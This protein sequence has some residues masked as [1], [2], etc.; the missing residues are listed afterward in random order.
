[1]ETLATYTQA[2]QEIT[3]ALF[4]SFVAF[5]DRTEKTTRTYLC[6]L[7]QFMAWLRY[8]AITQPTRPD[9][10][11]Y[12]QWLSTEH[13]AIVFDAASGWR[14]RTDRNGGRVRICCKA[15]TVKGYLQAVKEFFAWTAANGLYPNIAANVHAP[16]IT[17]THKKDALTGAEVLAIE[18]SITATT[19]RRV[20]DAEHA[21]RDP[22]GEAQRCTERGKRLYA[23]YLL[24]VNAG[25]RTV[26][27]SRA[28]V[29]DLE[30][31]DGHAYLY[32]WGKGHSEPDQRKPLAPAV[33]AALRDYL[34]SRTD[35]MTGSSPLFVATSNRSK[36]QRIASTTISTML[37][38]AM[39][40]A[41]FDSE[42]LTAHSL[43]HSTA[44]NVMLVTGRNIYDTQ[45]YLRHSSPK[46]TEIYLENDTTEAD[47]RIA[48]RLYAYYHGESN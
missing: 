21:R 11:S 10:L 16:R 18:R 30:Q 2:A 48:E 13:D 5:I 22:E 23:M 34:E 45:H 33:A 17:E 1:M 12:R 28:N 25:L 42:R 27:L 4:D 36:G 41:G 19:E 6:N 29:R 31:R 40:E 7:R 8:K 3:P 20:M 14:Y 46:T 37:K 26:E 44:A 15:T 32:I 47:E 43:R 24:A 9:I 38:K 39:Q 35:T